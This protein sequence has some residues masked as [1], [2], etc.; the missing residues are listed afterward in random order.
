[1]SKDDRFSLSAQEAIKAALLTQSTKQVADRLGVNKGTISK[2]KHGKV[3]VSN[4]IL[5]A[6]GLPLRGIEVPPCLKCG[7]AHTVAW[8][9]KEVGEARPPVHHKPLRV[10]RVDGFEVR[11][12]SASEAV[13]RLIAQDSIVRTSATVEDDQGRGVLYAVEQV[14]TVRCKRVKSKES[15]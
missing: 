12:R 7:E 15:K 8:C 5:G 3:S 6:L 11:A 9:T 1:M 13:R 4:R 10:W 2:I 14:T